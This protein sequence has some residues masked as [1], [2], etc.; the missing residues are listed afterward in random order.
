MKVRSPLRLYRRTLFIIIIIMVL[1]TILALVLLSPLALGG[2]AHYRSNWPLLSNIGQTYGA[3]SALLSSVA[4]A[5]VVLSLLYQARDSKTA[6]EQTTRSLQLELIKM[7]M[8]DPALM[9]AS[10]APW[11]LAIPSESVSIREFLYIQIWISYL[12]GSYIIGEIS[13]STLRYV[14]ANELFRSR[15]G[16]NY[17]E[18][19]SEKQSMS[20]GSRRH[21]HFY[22]ILGEEYQKARSNNAPV[23]DPVRITEHVAQA[24]ARQITHLSRA[25]HVALLA[26]A[27]IGGTLAG[28][29]WRRNKP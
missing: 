25:Q 11:G 15:A 8:E 26:T 19:R 21:N 16:R 28:R 27:A 18:A 17:W 20:D 9:T 7:Q 10:G 1:A 23:S 29:L 24:R 3:V 13:E 14:F 6:R 12:Y 5:G 4:L 2:L 22:R